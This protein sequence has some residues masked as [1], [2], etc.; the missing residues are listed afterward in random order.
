[1]PQLAPEVPEP[2]TATR[3]RLAS[4]LSQMVAHPEYPCL[5]A[6]SVFQRDRATVQVVRRA[7]RRRR[8]R[9]AAGRPEDLRRGDRSRAGVRLLR[10]DVPRTRGARRAALRATAVVAAGADPLGGRRTPG[11][12][13]CRPT[14]ATST[15]PSA[16]AVRRTSSSGCT[17]RAS[18]DARRTP[19]PTLV[20]NLHEQFEALRASGRFPRMRDKIRERDDQLQGSIN[21]M[22]AD[23]GETSEARQY[24]GRQVGPALAGA[25]LPGPSGALVNRL[26]P[27]TGTGFLL[28][29]GT[30]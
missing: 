22:V 14:P 28:P 7:G 26:A 21:P 6:R 23:H 10:R 15:S 13:R 3:H 1:M 24:S 9:A 8:R 20:F 12:P 18:R 25:V 11:T 19:T 29:P 16:P 2:A 5:G 4:M 17:P 27:Q 30:R